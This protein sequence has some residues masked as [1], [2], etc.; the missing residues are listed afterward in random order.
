MPPHDP[1]FR[2]HRRETALQVLLPIVLGG[3]LLLALG[4]WWATGDAGA[5]H[6]LADLALIGL[7]LPCLVLGLIPL[8]LLVGAVVGLARLMQVLPGPLAQIQAAVVRARQAVVAAADRA[9]APWIGIRSRVAALRS[10]LHRWRRGA[11]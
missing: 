7:L 6:R 1:A 5:V 8:A 11:P 4:V 2:K 9:A 3:I 10:V